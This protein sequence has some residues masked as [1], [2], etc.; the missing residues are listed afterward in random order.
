MSTS[1][2]GLPR[3]SIISLPLT[4]VMADMDLLETMP[5]VR[6]RAAA[7]VDAIMIKGRERSGNGSLRGNRLSK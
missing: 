4:P 2:V 6:R 3:E 5:G 1:T 7:A